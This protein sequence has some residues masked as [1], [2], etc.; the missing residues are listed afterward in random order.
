M[1]INPKQFANNLRCVRCERGLTQRALGERI[2]FSEKTVS[3]WECGAAIPDVETLFSIAEVLAT[4]IEALFA[5]GERYYLGID[6][7]GTKTELLLS[8]ADGTILRASRVG[9]CNPVDIGLDGAKRILRDAIYEICRGIRMSSVSMFAGIAGGSTSGVREELASFFSS[10]GFAH[11]Q[12]DSDNR[13]IIAAGL[14]K[15]DGMTVILGTG[16]CIYT[17]KSGMH[18]RISGWG[19]LLDDGGS[20]FNLGRDALHAYYAAYDG[21]GDKTLLTEEIDRLHPGGAEKLLPYVYS[22]GKRA[23]ASFAPAVFAACERGDS[24]A[25][26]ILDR[27]VSHAASLIARAAE[28]LD[29]EK[30]PIVLAGGLTRVPCMMNEL[31]RVLKKNTRYAVEILQ[32]EPV[33]GTIELAKNLEVRTN[34]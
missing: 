23:V 8:D 25:K 27:N 15:K 14:G 16:F 1:K 17:Q 18:R 13:N 5:D 24:I 32:C 10:F 3:K 26:T 28:T 2:G 22:E 34:E 30:I 21:T 6:G 9:A 20:G 33:M 12:N 29:G 4:N 31:M 11:F 19:Y 7:G